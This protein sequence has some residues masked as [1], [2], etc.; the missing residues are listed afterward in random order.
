MKIDSVGT[1]LFPV[2]EGKDGR[3]DRQTDMTKPIV[4][5]V[6]LLTRLKASHI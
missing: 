2:D 5:F 3:M 4:L 6:I 1:K